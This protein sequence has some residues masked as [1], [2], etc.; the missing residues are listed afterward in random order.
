M[1]TTQHHFGADVTAAC[2]NSGGYM[3][4]A[5]WVWLYEGQEELYIVGSLRI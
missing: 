5:S 3:T 4:E 2:E 1:A